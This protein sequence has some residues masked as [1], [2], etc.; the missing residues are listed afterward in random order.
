MRTGFFGRKKRWVYT[1]LASGLSAL[2][3]CGT[4]FATESGEETVDGYIYAYTLSA[5]SAKATAMSQYR[6]AVTDHNIYTYVTAVEEREDDITQRKKV[7]ASNSR[8]F[9]VGNTPMGV[10]ATATADNGYKIVSADSTHA[11]IFYSALQVVRFLEI[12]VEQT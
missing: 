6:E 10:V 7:S 2:M 4:A 3:M 5:S 12:T 9:S 11:L 8:E 1:L